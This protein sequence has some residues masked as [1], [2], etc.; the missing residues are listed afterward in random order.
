MRRGNIAFML[1]AVSGSRSRSREKQR[2]GRDM[3][4]RSLSYRLGSLKGDRRMR[5]RPANKSGEE[6]NVGQCRMSKTSA[7]LSGTTEIVPVC[8]PAHAGI[9]GSKNFSRTTLEKSLCATTEIGRPCA[10][11]IGG[12]KDCKDVE[13]H[14]GNK[15]IFSAPWRSAQ[16][17]GQP[18]KGSRTFINTTLEKRADGC[19]TEAPWKSCWVP[20][21]SPSPEIGLRGGRARAGM[22]GSSNFSNTT[23]E[24][25]SLEELLGSR[26]QP[27]SPEIGLR[28]GRARAGMEGSSNFSNTTLERRADG[29]LTKAPWKSCWVPGCSPPPQGSAQFA[30]QPAQG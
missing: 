27:P 16:F 20:G 4:S 22:E 6:E 7:V 23:L 26:L 11:A 5:V 24:R 19:L 1:S 13:R 30:G 8:G 2:C 12:N 25:S 3:T 9:K 15:V 10:S 17:A 28:G 14:F 29:C 21:C 18:A